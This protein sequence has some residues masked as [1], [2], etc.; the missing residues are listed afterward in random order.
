MLGRRNRPASSRQTYKALEPPT[1]GPL[2]PPILGETNSNTGTVARGVLSF[3]S[4]YKLQAQAPSPELKGGL[5]RGPAGMRT[6]F[7][8]RRLFR[9]QSETRR[10]D[11]ANSLALVGAPAPGGWR[12][13]DTRYQGRPR[14]RR[15]GVRTRRKR[16]FISF[17]SALIPSRCRS[18]KSSSAK[19]V[20]N[21]VEVVYSNSNPTP[22]FTDATHHLRLSG[23]RF[24]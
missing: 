13:Q 10:Q 18:D 2:R 4:R 15:S 6:L 3:G 22:V 1:R 17:K 8:L 9:A 21:C 16:V 14:W 19:C 5:K 7:G 23:L 24:H 12:I 20:E 11:L